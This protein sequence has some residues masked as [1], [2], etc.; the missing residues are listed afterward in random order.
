VLDHDAGVTVNFHDG[1]DN[2]H[3]GGGRAGTLAVIACRL[4]G[5]TDHR[6]RCGVDAL[7]FSLR[8]RAF[9]DRSWLNR[10]RHVAGRVERRG[11]ESLGWLGDRLAGDRSWCGQWRL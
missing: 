11:V 1:C 2:L 4:L 6:V 3:W 7:G 10:A 9:G 5:D 8:G